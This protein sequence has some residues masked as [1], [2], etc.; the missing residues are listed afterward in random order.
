MR[1]WA[2]EGKSPPGLGARLKH[3]R[4][5][6]RGWTRAKLAAETGIKVATLAAMETGR[7]HIRPE[8]WR[9]IVTALS[10]D[11]LQVNGLL[12][13]LDLAAKLAPLAPPQSPKRKRAAA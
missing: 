10:V 1:A 6:A 3:W 5:A 11:P 13:P 9:K 7:Q 12:A 8:A 4:K 2:V